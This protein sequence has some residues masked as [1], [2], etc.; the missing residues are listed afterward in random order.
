MQIW[1]LTIH[2]KSGLKSRGL[3]DAEGTAKAAYRTSTQ[4]ISHSE[5]PP[6]EINGRYVHSHPV[7]LQQ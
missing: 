5:M 2:W 7:A 1:E 6:Y 4:G 3:F